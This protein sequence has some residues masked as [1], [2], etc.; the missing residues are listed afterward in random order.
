MFQNLH[1][2]IL[3]CLHK[4]NDFSLALSS[5]AISVELGMIVSKLHNY[6]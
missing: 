4:I 2:L 6:T 1:F 3:T 5:E